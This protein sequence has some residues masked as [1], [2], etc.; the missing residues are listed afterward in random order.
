MKWLGLLVGVS[1]FSIAYAQQPPAVPPPTPGGS[2]P[3]VS[4][5]RPEFA[6]PAS[7]PGAAAA[8]DGSVTLVELRDLIRAQTEAIRALSSKLDSAEDRLRRIEARLR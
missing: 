3:G 7:P 5:L 6:S 4:V 2:S 1:A 8:A